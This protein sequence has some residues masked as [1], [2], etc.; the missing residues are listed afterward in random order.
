MLI[1]EK[2]FNFPKTREGGDFNWV[3]FVLHVDLKERM[4]CIAVEVAIMKLG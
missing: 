3:I 1:A 2:S 4:F